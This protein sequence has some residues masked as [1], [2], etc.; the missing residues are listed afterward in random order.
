LVFYS[1]PTPPESYHASLGAIHAE[2]GRDA[3][4]VRHFERAD[5]V[6]PPSDAAMARYIHYY[7]GFAYLNLGDRTRARHA[8]A[9]Y[10][11]LSPDDE[12]IRDL[13]RRRRLDPITAL[14][15]RRTA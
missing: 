13:L 9:R 11:A 2:L 4:A 1:F 12:A 15:V 8:F 6:R 10:L 3:R 14:G 7:L 5:R